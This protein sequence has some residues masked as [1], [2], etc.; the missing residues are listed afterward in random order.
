MIVISFLRIINDNVSIYEN[1]NEKITVKGSIADIRI[2]PEHTVL[3]MTD[4][5]YNTGPPV[6]SSDKLSVYLSENEISQLKI[7]MTICV[8]GDANS[9]NHATNPGEFDTSSYYH[10]KGFAFMIYSENIRI[11]D[12]N[13]NHFKQYL[14]EISENLKS[15]YFKYLP[16]NK[17]SIISGII[18]GKRYLISEEDSSMYS[19]NGIMHLLAVSGMHVSTISVLI[20]WLM[21]HMP[22]SYIKARVVIILLLII[23]GFLTGFG[24]S[25]IRAIIMIILNI[26]AKLIGRPYDALTSI[27][28]AGIIILLINPLYL[29]EASFMLSFSAVTAV[30]VIT[31]YIKEKTES[32]LALGNIIVILITAPIILYFYNDIALYSVFINIIVIPIMSVL[33]VA[34]IL[35]VI[36]GSLFMPFGMFFAGT[37]NYV[38]D[39]Y[40]HV[41]GFFD[42]YFFGLRITGH[43]GLYI[44]LFYY[45]I[46]F[47]ML[48]FL[49]LSKNKLFSK[50]IYIGMSI[51]CLFILTFKPYNNNVCVT[52]L[53]VGQGDGLCIQS[54]N[55]KCIMIDGGSSDESNLAKYTLEPFFKYNGIRNIDIWFVSHND[56]DHVSGLL[57]ILERNDLNFITINTL[58][59]PKT[60]A[61]SHNEFQ[62]F[63]GRLVKNIIYLRAGDTI[64]CDG[65]RFI[66]SNPSENE[67]GNNDSSLVLS[68]KYKDF[69]MLFTGDVSS[70]TEKNILQFL[71][72][73]Y[74]VLKVAHHGSKYSTCNEFLSKIKP[75]AALISAGKYNSYGHPAEETL[76][77]LGECKCRIYKTM[78]VGAIM[79]HTDGTAFT[80]KMYLD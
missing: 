46:I 35:L 60:N 54:V 64:T 45:I 37:V 67:A 36:S 65:I 19:R 38:L 5:Y 74:D 50:I 68:M 61:L 30:T 73:D 57:S 13:Y 31:P 70:D 24:V 3:T 78:D 20:I 75:K 55:G 41:C 9:Y 53:D 33:F 8:D 18:L 58:V 56:I 34:A 26:I 80:V 15:L 63:E 2:K 40:E 4:I 79:I 77:R 51:I 29:F 17:A 27:S 23:Y 25:C 43:I 32:V 22:V 59:L 7:G 42:K 12:N 39:F 44:I 48:I 6:K 71:C 16:E 49:Y 76:K 21:S 28:F 47:T 66:C 52:M 11:L 14:F 72:N 10:N 69:N 62:K 1:I